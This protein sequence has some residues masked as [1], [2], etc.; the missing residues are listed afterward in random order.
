[1]S[2]DVYDGDDVEYDSIVVDYDGDE[3]AIVSNADIGLTLGLS[4]R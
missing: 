4:L 3:Q 1:M 2:D